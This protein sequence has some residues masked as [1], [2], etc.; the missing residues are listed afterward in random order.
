MVRSNP[1]NNSC[2]GALPHP[3]CTAAHDDSSSTTL[4][5][6]LHTPRISIDIAPSTHTTQCVPFV[7]SISHIN[8]CSLRNKLLQKEVHDI[9]TLLHTTS[10]R[11]DILAITE[12]WLDASF[13]LK[14]KIFLTMQHN[15]CGKV[16]TI[17]DKIKR[18][19]LQ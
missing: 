13:T 18:K 9:T 1:T 12:T 17:R 16:T 7:L 6:S 19:A 10:P 11:I 3:M 2:M 15:Y 8:I 5:V 14:K 4:N